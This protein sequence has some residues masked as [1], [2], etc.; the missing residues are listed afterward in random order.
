MIR[1]RLPVLAVLIWAVGFMEGMLI[2]LKV[3]FAWWEI[4]LLAIGYCALLIHFINMGGLAE[5]AMVVR[6]QLEEMDTK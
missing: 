2:A 4:A 6:R 5:W 1:W 3:P